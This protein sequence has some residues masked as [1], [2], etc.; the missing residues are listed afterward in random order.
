MLLRWVRG[1]R[2]RLLVCIVCIDDYQSVSPS[3]DCELERLRS[4]K[5]P[6]IDGVIPW[7]ERSIKI[8]VEG[9]GNCFPYSC[10]L[11]VFLWA[12]QDGERLCAFEITLKK[13]E[14]SGGAFGLVPKDCKV[15]RL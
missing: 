7:W 12:L 5:K 15:W 14:G 3:L 8:E 4:N 11:A 2:K 6:V 9:D 10:V 1:E 13:H